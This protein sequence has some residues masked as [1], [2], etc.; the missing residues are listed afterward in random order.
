MHAIDFQDGY[1]AFMQPGAP[2]A[3]QPN[4]IF[5]VGVKRPA[6]CKEQAHL[7]LIQTESQFA[8]AGIISDCTKYSMLPCSI[9]RQGQ[10]GSVR[11][12]L[13]STQK[14]KIPFVKCGQRS[15]STVKPQVVPI[16]KKL[17][18]KDAGADY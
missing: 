15:G 11:S 13:R 1:D 16:N 3:A 12:N 6:F 17:F 14:T 9:W 18:F 10:E 2:A 4:E 5:R 7:H 8:I